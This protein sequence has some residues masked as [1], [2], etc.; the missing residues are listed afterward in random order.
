MATRR[1]F[2][3]TTAYAALAAS[4]LPAAEE[5]FEALFNGADLSGWQGDNLLW[6]VEN[7]E[8]VGRSPGIGY[9]DFLATKAEYSDFIVRFQVRLV[10]DIGNS[11]LQFRS[12]RMK[13]SMEM[14]GYQADVGPS[15]WGD[16]YDESRRKV[17][18]V[19]ADPK[20]IERIVKK[21]DWNDY[22]VHAEGKHIKL[23]L[24]GKVT[25]EYE[26]AES[27]I[28]GSGLIAVQIHGGPPLEVRFRDIRIKKL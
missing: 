23:T 27:G 4:S 10:D 8:L 3:K 6:L 19:D 11:G 15:W 9:N 5:G 2:L 25:A 14:I 16:L 26:E 22:E 12:E 13:G 28:A 17:T 7:G 24:N 20:L 21:N 18:L 1:L